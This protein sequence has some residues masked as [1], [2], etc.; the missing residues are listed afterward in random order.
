MKIATKAQW[1]PTLYEASAAIKK[2][3]EIFNA[4]EGE[5]VSWLEAKYVD[6]QERMSHDLSSKLYTSSTG[7]I[8]L[9][10]GVAVNP[11]TGTYAGIDRADTT[12]SR[13]WRNQYTNAVSLAAMTLKMLMNLYNNCSSGQGTST[14]DFIVTT[15]AVWEEM[16][17]RFRDS[18]T[19]VNDWKT[20]PDIEIS[21]PAIRLFGIKTPIV[22]DAD[23]PAGYLYMLNS[24]FVKLRT[25]PAA[26]MT[27]TPWKEL[28][29]FA[30]KGKTC[31]VGGQLCVLAPNRC[32][33]MFNLT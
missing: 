8:G 13:A 23:C 25:Y 2:Q 12:Y 33:V 28:E 20:D 27:Q 9:Q 11:T 4:G 22:W 7:W 17:V 6:L 26:D 29:S 30:G 14:P 18:L 5:V 3:D 10:T 1:E 15:Q 21:Y 31:Y 19:I 32:G 24:K 16:T